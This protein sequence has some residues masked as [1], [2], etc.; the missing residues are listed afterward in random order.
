MQVWATNAYFPIVP[1]AQNQSKLMMF[2]AHLLNPMFMTYLPLKFHW[3]LQIHF[4]SIQRARVPTGREHQDY[5]VF[6]LIPVDSPV[7]TKQ[8]HS[9]AT[10][11]TSIGHEMHLIRTSTSQWL[12]PR[13]SATCLPLIALDCRINQNTLL[14]NRYTQ[15]LQG[16]IP[17]TS[18][19]HCALRSLS[20]PSL[21]SD[22]RAA[23][24]EATTSTPSGLKITS[25]RST[26]PASLLEPP[27][28]THPYR[29]RRDSWTGGHLRAPAS[30]SSRRPRVPRQTSPSCMARATQPRPLCAWD[31]TNVAHNGGP[32]P[33]PAPASWFGLR[34]ARSLR[35]VRKPPLRA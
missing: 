3:R 33:A 5:P 12:T 8:A 1:T 2:E 22:G 29:P 21:L 23:P 32:R 15:A 18:R 27:S 19:R 20:R 7:L 14:C 11:R 9:S 10:S 28:S 17:G 25:I 35:S 24:L 26:R 4:C 16:F 30:S 31:R 6:A 13:I 34:P